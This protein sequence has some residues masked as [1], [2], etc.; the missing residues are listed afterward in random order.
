[1]ISVHVLVESR[2]VNYQDGALKAHWKQPLSVGCP[3]RTEVFGDSDSHCDAFWD[4]ICV[5]NC[6]S[7]NSRQ[8]KSGCVHATRGFLGG[9]K[10]ALHSLKGRQYST[11][12]QNRI[13][14]LLKLQPCQR[15]M[16][17]FAYAANLFSLSPSLSTI[18]C[19]VCV[20]AHACLIFCR[21]LFDVS[22]RALP[23]FGTICA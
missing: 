5:T 7:M 15:K 14:G 21:L 8:T 22:E 17:Y 11:M 6:R 16:L 13:R 1:M 12:C 10:K 3:K 4:C 23:V 9:E 19:R 2:P 20:C 18:I